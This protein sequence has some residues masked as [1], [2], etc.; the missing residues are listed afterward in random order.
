MLATKA[1]HPRITTEILA[2]ALGLKPA[3]IRVRLCRTGSYFGIRPIKLPN[4]RLLWPSDA[5]EQLS[6]KNA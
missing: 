6:S 2:Q 3:S 5:V 4:G 1:P